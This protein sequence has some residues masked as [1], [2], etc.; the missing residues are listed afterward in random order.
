MS[1]RTLPTDPAGIA[2]WCDELRETCHSARGRL[3]VDLIESA[4]AD[5][6]DASTSAKAS[7]ATAVD[8]LL[9]RINVCEKEWANEVLAE[10][11][12]RKSKGDAAVARA[13]KLKGGSLKAV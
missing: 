2:I 6:W 12:L 3:V 1:E 10:L 7:I 8:K 4:M 11:R 13:R 5:Y 9:T